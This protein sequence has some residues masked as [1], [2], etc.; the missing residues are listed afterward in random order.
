[1]TKQGHCT[2]FIILA[3]N[4]S[5]YIIANKRFFIYYTE[6]LQKT[7]KLEFWIIKSTIGSVLPSSWAMAKCRAVSSDG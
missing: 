7:H 2:F 1:M 4:Q 5:K 3:L 6:T